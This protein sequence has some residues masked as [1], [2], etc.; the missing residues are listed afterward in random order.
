MNVNKTIKKILLGALTSLVALVSCSGI[1]YPSSAKYIKPIAQNFQKE[2][3]H[4]LQN[5]EIKLL[6]ESELKVLLRRS[7]C[8]EVKNIS[9]KYV[10]QIRKENSRFYYKDFKYMKYE[11]TLKTKKEDI[12]TQ[13]VE[14][15]CIT[16]DNKNISVSLGLHR[17]R[18]P[19]FEFHLKHTTC[20]DLNETV[21]YCWTSKIGP[22]FK[23]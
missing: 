13:W 5:K 15:T 23:Q 17:N 16:E 8:V 6:P 14:L 7:G 2:L 18:Y 4:S 1:K 9:N 10:A 22:S 19:N 20:R 3:I 12:V 11:D 21:T